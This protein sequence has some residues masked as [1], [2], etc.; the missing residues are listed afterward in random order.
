MIKKLLLFFFVLF[1]LNTCQTAFAKISDNRIAVGEIYPGMSYGQVRKIYGDADIQSGRGFKSWGNYLEIS[2][3]DDNRVQWVHT[4]ESDDIYTP[5][6]I[7]IGMSAD[8]LTRIYG[9]ADFTNDG[10][11]RGTTSYL[12]QGNTRNTRRLTFTVDSNGTI[13][14]ISAED[15]SVVNSIY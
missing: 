3:S 13:I 14:K 9:T 2:F 7:C 10:A 15:I 6:G 12:Y 4:N 1:L 11:V 5:D 8:M